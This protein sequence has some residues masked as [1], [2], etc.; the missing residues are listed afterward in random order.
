MG[1]SRNSVNVLRDYKN[2]KRKHMNDNSYCVIM[3]GGVGSRVW[4][5]SRNN[6]PKQFLDILGTGETLIQQTYKRFR[7]N[8]PIA[9]FFVVTNEIYKDIVLQQL[10]D[11]KAEQVLCEPQRR[12]TAPC[13]AYATFKIKTINPKATIVVTP[14][15]HLIVRETEFI[16]AVSI[17][18]SHAENSENL[19]TLGIQPTRIET[20]YGYIQA[21]ESANT[22]HPRLNKVKAFTEKPDYDTAKIFFETGGF[23]WNSGV[24]IWSVDAI[25]HSFSKYLPNLFLLFKQGEKKY[26]TADE[27]RFIH[28]CYADCESISID[29][30][31]MEKAEN[32]YVIN[33]DFGWSDLGTWGSLYEMKEKDKHGNALTGNNAFLF[34]SENC[35][36]QMPKGKV[37]MASGLHDM[38]VVESDG[39]LLI[40]PKKDEQ[41]IKEYTAEV[42]KKIGGSFL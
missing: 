17:A 34:N 20:G 24:F 8:I 28:E 35:L 7:K 19:I 27:V 14:A 31:I 41:Q 18:M 1:L 9:N 30:G 39:M 26:N 6:R 22:P 13:I 33:G 10:P 29:Y 37:L 40:C 4:A 36:V 38:I 42:E 21:L 15:D 11:L 23:Y 2:K 32:V 16:D 3:A 12:N 25:L 5:L